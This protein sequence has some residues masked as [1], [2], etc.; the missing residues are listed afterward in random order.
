MKWTG[1]FWQDRVRRLREIYATRDQVGAVCVMLINKSDRPVSVHIDFARLN[2][3]GRRLQL[4]SLRGVSDRLD[5]DQV[6][7]NGVRSPQPNRTLLPPPRET[8]ARQRSLAQPM[9]PYS[10]AT[11][12]VA[13][14]P[15]P[16]TES[17]RRGPG[18]NAG[19]GK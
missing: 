5:D 15:P 11:L 12:N 9:P 1:S 4:H 14:R 16:P 18:K 10:L 3:T 2:P 6:V 17:S 19:E 13:A 8:V 7:Y